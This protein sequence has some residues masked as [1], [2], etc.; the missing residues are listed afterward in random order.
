[1]IFMILSLSL[2]SRLGLIFPGNDDDDDVCSMR[3][4]RVGCSGG[5]CYYIY[6]Y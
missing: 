3:V 1:M 4:C 2:S 6:Y 5:V